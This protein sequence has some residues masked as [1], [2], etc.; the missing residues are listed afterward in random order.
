MLFFIFITFFSFNKGLFFI[1]V[2]KIEENRVDPIF[3]SLDKLSWYAIFKVDSLGWVLAPVRGIFYFPKELNSF[4]FQKNR[5]RF[6]KSALIA[7]TSWQPSLVC[8][9]DNSDFTPNL[10]SGLYFFPINDS[11]SS[12]INSLLM[13]EWAIKA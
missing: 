3:P 1:S 12:F 10:F 4:L 9:T 5:P 11:K 6:Q 7:H 8:Y 2:K 13:S